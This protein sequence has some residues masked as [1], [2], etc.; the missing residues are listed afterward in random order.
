MDY[1]DVILKRVPTIG[2]ELK[3]FQYLRTGSF[4]QDELKTLIPA[5]DIPLLDQK[6][7]FNIMP[8]WDIGVKY[9]HAKKISL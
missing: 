3:I 5:L 7:L 8:R 9:L 1:R 2:E 6:R 4:H